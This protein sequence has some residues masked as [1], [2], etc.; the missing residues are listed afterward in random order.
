MGLQARRV[1]VEEVLKKS[2]EDRGKE[3]DSWLSQK[4]Y[5][6]TPLTAFQYCREK[7][8][9]RYGERAD[10]TWGLDL[11][12]GIAGHKAVEVLHATLLAGGKFY[13]V[14]AREVIKG[15]LQRLRH[16][17]DSHRPLDVD[18]SVGRILPLVE[19]YARSWT[20]WY[21]AVERVEAVFGV[22]EEVTMGGKKV[23]GH[24][25]LESAD[26]LVVDFKFVGKQSRHRQ[27]KPFDLGMEM[28]K[29]G[30]QAKRT[31]IL[32]FVK[33]PYTREPKD[34]DG[35][36]A[37]GRAHAGIWVIDGLKEVKHSP[38][39]ANAAEVLIEMLASE[40]EKGNLS[41]GPPDGIGN[42]LCTPRYCSFF[43][44]CRLTCHLNR[45]AFEK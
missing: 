37:I 25:D 29:K 16:R 12:E 32:P 5:A 7:Y 39:S 30:T 23:A 9:M 26:R 3:H 8:R 41:G 28:Y 6:K 27:P 42:G 43:G 2:E 34:E 11:V 44:R 13:P 15:E 35:T 38:A 22:D 20:R 4:R 33:E 31:A 17:L 18:A 14:E 10:E 24:I 45:K 36:S 21:P 40:I 19:L 1:T